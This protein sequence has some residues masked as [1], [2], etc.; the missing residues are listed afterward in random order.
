MNLWRLLL[1]RPL[2]DAEAGTEQLDEVSGVSVLGLDALSSAAYGPEAALTVLIPLG[3][4]GLRSILPI[5][6]TIVLL[7]VVVQVSYRQTIG[8]YPDGGGSYTVSK[9]NL[10]RLP[11]LTAAAALCVDYVLNVAVAIAAGVSALASAIPALLPHTL[12]LCLALLALLTIVNL[13]GLRTAGVV[14]MVPTYLFVGSMLAIIVLGTARGLLSGLHPTPVVAPPHLQPA[15]EAGSLWVMA[16]AFA[17]GCT[18]LTGVEAVSNAVP[19][20]KEP[21]QR[22]AE[23]TLAIILFTLVV[24]LIGIAPMP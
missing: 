24:L 10:G 23:R 3:A 1:G 11:G 19:V 21:R 2:A 17:A 4:A 18:A 5:T 22:R 20:F 16:R 15:I 6:A 13:R 14:F 9:E 8:A 7:L 12:A